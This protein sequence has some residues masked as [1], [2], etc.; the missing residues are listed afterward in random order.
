MVSSA[1]LRQPS[2]NDRKRTLPQHFDTIGLIGKHADPTP[3]ETLLRVAG[4]L[5]Q[6]GQRVLLEEATAGHFPGHGLDT[7]SLD[8]IGRQC[9][10]AI[11]VGGDG[12][13]LHAA[14][15]LA[16]QGVPLIGI[17]LGRLG[18]L[19]DIS[20]D[21]MLTALEQI[22]G[23]KY[24]EE[25]RFMLHAEIDG[26]H[27]TALNDVVIH[28]WNIARMIELETYIDGTFVEAQRSDGLIISTPTGSTAY[29][30]SGGGPLLQP[31]LNAIL[32]VPICP[33]TLSNRPVVINGDSVIE[34]LVS[35]N[36]RLSHVRVTCDG[37]TC[38]PLGGNRIRIRKHQHPVRLI[39]PLDHDHFNILRAKLGW[40]GHPV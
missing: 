10:L 38:L 40:S 12:T 13:L 3:G 26:Q 19:A 15:S 31:D 34:I 14:R 32:M 2:A 8:E 1:S 24:A 16:D 28:K 4:F 6:R 20:P 25:Q 27:C 33:H 5:R 17:N 21:G 35:S 22:F 37:Q 29:A 9:D 11:V 39:H 7:A 23:G 30:L 18:F 36:T